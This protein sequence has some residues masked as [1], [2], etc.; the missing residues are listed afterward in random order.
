MKA[1]Y[2]E[3]T[4]PPE[5]IRYGDLPTPVPGEREVLV[6]VRAVVVNLIDTYIRSGAYAIDLPLLFIIGRDMTGDVVATGPGVTRFAPGDRV[7]CNNQGYDGRQG[8]FAE[9]LAI[10]ERLLYPLPDGV[11]PREAVTVLHS[12]LTAVLGL[13]AR[14]RLRAGETVFLNG[15]DGNVGTAVLQL[16]RATGA[17][18]AVTA[19]SEPKALWC[20]QLGADRVISYKSEDV[21]QALHAFAPDGV[22]VYWDATGRPDVE[23]ALAVL[24][25]RGRIV[26]MSG[27]KHRCTLPV[28]AFYTKNCTMFG[29]TVTDA[30]IE[31]LAAYAV[32]INSGLAK[33]VL[34]GKVHAILPLAQAAEANRMVERGKLF[35]KI[36]LVPEE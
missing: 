6:R 25:R 14:A 2:I 3:R 9:L 5:Q 11:E 35:G 13:F 7:W 4:G 12:A 32:E 24:A 10:D 20:R 27:L 1:A 17:R 22:N 18:V 28:G 34:K 26:L 36:V 29:F 30:T 23:Q 16:A 31:E 15:G 33:G 21:H 8:T 19:G